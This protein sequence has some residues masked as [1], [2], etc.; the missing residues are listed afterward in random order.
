MIIYAVSQISQFNNHP[1]EEHDAAANRIFNYLRGT[2]SPGITFD[3]KVGLEM[4]AYSDA[5]WGGVFSVE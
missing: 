3:G 5:N 1:S 4:M 2:P